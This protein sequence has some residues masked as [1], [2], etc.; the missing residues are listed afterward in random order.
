MLKRSLTAI[1][2]L[3]VVIVI[4][5]LGNKYVIDAVVAVLA[6]AAIYEYMKCIRNKFKPIYWIGFLCAATISLLHVIP[7]EYL[8]TYLPLGILAMLA[9]FF[10]HVVFTDMK[11]NFADIAMNFFG[12]IYIV[13]LF[14]FVAIL[15]GYQENAFPLGKLYVGYLFLATWGC[16]VFAYLVGTRFGKHKFSKIS[17]KKS[18]EGCLAGTISG[19]VLVLIATV[20]YNKFFNLHINYLVISIIALII[21]LLGQIGDFS[22]SCIKRYVE[23]KD[24]SNILPGHGGIIDRFDS[25]IFA[26]PF[27]YYL[28]TLLI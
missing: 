11:I 7:H 22:A 5:V 25:V 12:V 2:G 6:I 9:I 1:I 14:A 27:A 24:F 15:H 3:P 26:A 13:G 17:P 21:N 4:L 19:I 10:M 28:I 20:L 16:D 18:I 23:V 8:I